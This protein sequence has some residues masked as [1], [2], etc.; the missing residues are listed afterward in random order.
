MSKNTTLNVATSA[1]VAPALALAEAYIDGLAPRGWHRY[2]LKAAACYNFG[3]AEGW[4][5]AMGVL[6]KMVADDNRVSG[7]AMMAR[8][9][10]PRPVLN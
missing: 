7:E 1:Q 4:M 3:D 10:P 6:V 8:L 9:T 5:E 2:V